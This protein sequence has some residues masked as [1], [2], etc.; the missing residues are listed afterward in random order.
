MKTNKWMGD[1][2]YETILTVR[3]CVDTVGVRIDAD[4]DLDRSADRASS[5]SDRDG[6]SGSDDCAH[7]AVADATG[8]RTHTAADG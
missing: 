8:A 6:R 5:H 3:E 4:F 2:R 1:L 7:R